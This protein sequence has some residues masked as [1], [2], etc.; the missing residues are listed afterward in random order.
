MKTASTRQ[1]NH[2][3]RRK[4]R[5]G[6][7]TDKQL[8]LLVFLLISVMSSPVQAFDITFRGTATVPGSSITL[9]EIA[10]INSDS[11]LAQTLGSQSVAASPD[12][13]QKIILD[14]R[15]ISKKITDTVAD[16]AEIQWHGASSVTVERL[17]NT[18]TT[19][20][21]L[22]IIN[23]YI[24]ERAKELPK[25]HYTFSPKEPPLPFLVPVGDI[26]WDVTPSNPELVGSKRFSIIGRIDNRVIKNFSVHGTLEAIAHVAVA[27][28]SLRRDDLITASQI[29]MEP[30]DLSELRAPCLQPN[31]VVGKKL[32]RNIKAGAAI[33]LT[34]L[35]FPPL[36]KKGGLVKIL[37]QKNGL[38]LTA[39]G[40]AKTDGKQDQIIKVKNI[41]SDKE[42]FARVAA[43][44]LVEV[45]I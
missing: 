18:L 4:Q 20:K 23:S 5:S 44:G 30:R 9:A 38:E 2:G 33:E 25:A 43:P 11:E 39:S 36:V 22:E 7:R 40:I 37:C 19:Q 45:Q 16:P 34:A 8:V 24:R 15:T 32:L 35:E 14:T 12:A 28:S 31:Q 3:K 17:G 1:E 13:G 42:I 27:A 10:V 21:I 26:K 41:S 29:Q 6:S